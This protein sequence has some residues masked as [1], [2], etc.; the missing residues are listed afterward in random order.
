MRA[1]RV[2]LTLAALAAGL[3]FAWPAAAAGL[4][5]AWQAASVND[6]DWAVANA[7]R[8]AAAPRRDQAQALWR[9]TVGLNASLGVARSD[10][11]TEGAQFSAPGFGSVR[12]ADFATSV[13]AGASERWAIEARQPL[14]SPERRARQRQLELGADRADLEWQAA[15]EQLMLRTAER[16]FKLALAL[17]AERVVARQLA[18]VERAAAEAEDRFRLGD[19]PV[20][21]TREAQA[22]LAE[23]RARHLAA[24][25]DT[26]SAREDLADST[27]LPAA[28]LQALLPGNAPVAPGATLDTWLAEARSGNPEIRLRELE[29]EIARV[30]A[31]RYSRAAA[32]SVDLVAQ[33]GREHLSGSGDFGSG[34]YGA[35]NAMV[36]IQLSVPLFSGG[37]REAREREGQRLADAASA[38]TE[39]AR[40]QTEQAVRDAW[41]GL[42]L[43]AARVQALGA[44]VAAAE[45]R[46]DATRLGRQVGDR[47]TLDLL[48]AENASAASRLA[49]A[50]AKVG[51][52][53]D[54]LRLSALAGRL[55]EP[56]LQ[57]VD[58]GLEAAPAATHP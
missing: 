3:A 29:G 31:T 57:V 22:R 20:T 34:A 25:A 14:Y 30:D 45:A 55:D 46:L 5:Q 15:R 53:L 47:T 13:N 4:I 48:E 27:G 24:H 12:G 1:P 19:V 17:E 56:L 36:G 2:A 43:G 8:A 58:R 38:R 18:A 41:R 9:P 42:E 33:A 23:L 40:R 44:A 28:G 10:T 52:V 32:P 37:Y 6:R 35:T 16:Y 51:W 11:A 26:E 39:S 7:A 54:R 49:L 21:D 50:Q